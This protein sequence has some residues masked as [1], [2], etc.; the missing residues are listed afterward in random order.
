MH[1]DEGDSALITGPLYHANAFWGAML[2]L[3]YVGGRMA[4]LS[5][6]DA[7]K[8]LQAIDRYKPTYMAGTPSMYSLLLAAFH[9]HPVYAVSSLQFLTCGS[10]PVTEELL[11]SLQQ[12]FGCVVV[13]GYGMTETGA[14]IVTPRW[15]IK[16][17]GSTGLP[18][19]EAEAQVVSVDDESRLC[20]VGEIGELWSRGPA[21]TLGYYKQ[22]DVTAERIT[23]DGWLKTRD[24]MSADED[25]YFYFRGRKDDMINVGGE[26]VYPKEIEN[27]LL[28]HPAIADVAVV[29]AP[30]QVKG[31]APV[32]WVVLRTDAEGSPESSEAAIKQFYLDRGPAYAHPRRVFFV[33]ELPLTGTNKLDRQWLTTESARR[34]PQGIA[35][36][37]SGAN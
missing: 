33:D 7:V 11:T 28:S 12:T 17:L 35:G 27:V 21:N 29:A 3:L 8:V 9:A 4:I 25:G 32:A 19:P 23:P 22:P 24:L 26:N 1:V 36:G 10:A 2:P 16:K 30:H 14:N 13:E 34:I 37:Q 31:E 15:G 18:V 5:G 20:A 6:F